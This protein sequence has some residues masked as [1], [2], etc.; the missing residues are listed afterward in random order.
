[1]HIKLDLKVF[2]FMLL[3]LLMKKIEIYSILMIFGLIHELAHLVAGLILGMKPDK[4]EIYP[5]GFKLAFKINYEDYNVKINN[6]T[7]LSIKKILIYLAGPLVNFLIVLLALYNSKVSEI[8][9]MDII[10]AN[11]LIAVFNL[12]PIYPMD[13][14]KIVFEL[15]HI[16]CGLKKSYKY[17]QDI[18]WITLILLSV[19]TSFLVLYLKNI[20][21]LITIIYLWIIVIRGGK[22]I[23]IKESII[24]NYECISK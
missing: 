21:I 20:T 17:I 7:Q 11:L 15:L 10:Y 22:F 3:F 14:G 4:I 9:R 2:L 16:F 19:L 1:M 8:A 5:Y 13:G 6:G 12:L 24:E 23:R 18:T